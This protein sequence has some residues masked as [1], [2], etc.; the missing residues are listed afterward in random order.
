MRRMQ[1]DAGGLYCISVH[2]HPP[3]L[4]ATVTLCGVTVSASM[5]TAAA[6]GL[7]SVYSVVLEMFVCCMNLHH[8]KPGSEFNF[9]QAPKSP[10]HLLTVSVLCFEKP[11]KGGRPVSGKVSKKVH[12]AS[13][14]CVAFLVCI[15]VPG[16]QPARACW[17][18]LDC[19][20]RRRV[21]AEWVSVST[22]RV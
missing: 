15:A 20:A 16:A 12:N 19:C 5:T 6:C 2:I 13:L 8:P 21:G 10:S 18:L 1:V 11:N 14:E 4:G 22:E 3:R 9:F 7:P 17:G